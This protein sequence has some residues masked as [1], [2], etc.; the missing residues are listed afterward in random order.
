MIR[1]AH[2]EVRRS[3]REE[4]KIVYASEVACGSFGGFALQNNL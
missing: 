3:A 1:T 4:V 2:R